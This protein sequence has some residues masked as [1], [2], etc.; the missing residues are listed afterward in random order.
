MWYINSHYTDEA[1][2]A[3]CLHRNKILINKNKNKVYIMQ[4]LNQAQM[5]DVNGGIFFVVAPW[6][7]KAVFFTEAAIIAA[8]AA[9]M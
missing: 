7:V 5:Q 8:Y 1:K 3:Y 2:L 6:I 9:N 4:T